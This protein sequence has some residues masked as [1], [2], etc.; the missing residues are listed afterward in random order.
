MT[1]AWD[2]KTGQPELRY[3]SRQ[4][5]KRSVQADPF[6]PAK[7]WE[8]GMAVLPQVLLNY[9]KTQGMA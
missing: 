2:E 5:E 4:G 9:L 6:C 3:F 8:L 7:A 1:D